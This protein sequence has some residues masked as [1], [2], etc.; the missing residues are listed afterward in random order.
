MRKNIIQG[1]LGGLLVIA[2]SI[3]A[4]TVALAA[5]PPKG[6]KGLKGQAGVSNTAFIELWQKD[7]DWKIVADGAWG[8]MKYNLQGPTFD[9]L[10]NGHKLVPGTD[11]QL[12]YYPD[13]WPGNGLVC[14]GAGTANEEGDV[15]IIGSTDTGNLPAVN[16]NVLGTWKWSVLNTYLHDIVIDA[17]NLDGTFSGHGGYPAGESYIYTEVITGQ[18]T[19]NSIT[20]H[21]VYAPGPYSVTASGEI[22]SDG[23]I[24]GTNPWSW[25]M[26]EGKAK[27]A[28]AKIWLVLSGDVKCNES[29]HMTG[30]N[31]DGYLFEY[32]SIRYTETDVP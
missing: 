2:L 4:V 12:I 25:K 19:G 10:F 7:S 24:S 1:V 28:G 32:D 6:E 17:Q 20:I 29:S 22:A 21:T 26:I 16:W 23:T 31:S 18:I 5:Q 13:P 30:W 3:T 9:Y 14:L 11:Y 27:P 15:H 8:K